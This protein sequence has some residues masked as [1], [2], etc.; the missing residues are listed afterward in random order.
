MRGFPDKAY[1]ALR[2]QVLKRDNFTCQYCG[3]H[4]PNVILHVDHIIEVCDGGGDEPD[5][6]VTACSACNVG[7]EALRSQSEGKKGRLA[8]R[9]PHRWRLEKKHPNEPKW[10]EMVALEPRLSDL[11]KEVISLDGSKGECFCPHDH[12]FGRDGG[13]ESLRN[14]LGMLVGFDA[15]YGYS[16]TCD[17]EDE[18]IVTVGNLPEL[19]R[20]PVPALLASSL[21]YD[22]AYRKLY[23]LLPPHR[24][25]Y[26]TEVQPWILP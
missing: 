16:E 21:A 13:K 4:A 26:H 2:F 9:H 10:E 17:A 18:G 14:R 5:N 22:A 6:L 25:C 15:G 11:L 3:Q 19:E 12:W 20:Q 1:Y 24:N 7:K 23:E 8:R